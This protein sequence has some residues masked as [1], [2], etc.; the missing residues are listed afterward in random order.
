MN[1]DI[2]EEKKSLRIGVIDSGVGGMTVAGE[3]S[4]L[5]LIRT[6][7]ILGTARM[8]PMAIKP[9]RK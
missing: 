7:S 5:F 6:S 1:A 9:K 4:R 3:L 2:A 8:S